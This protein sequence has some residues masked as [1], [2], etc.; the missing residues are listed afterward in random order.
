M[1]CLDTAHHLPARLL[2]LQLLVEPCPAARSSRGSPT[3][4]SRV[5]RSA[6]R[7]R[8]A[9]AATVP[10]SASRS[11]AAPLPCCRRSSSGAAASCSRRPAQR[12]VE[13]ELQDV[14][15][16]VARVRRVVGHVVLGA[17]V[18]E[19]LAARRRRRDA[20][21]LQPQVPPRLVVVR[22]RDLAGEHLPAPLVDQQAE[23][24]ER[25]LLERASQQQPDVARGI[26]APCRAGRSSR[27]IR[28]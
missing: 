3:R 12:A 26:R 22:R 18:E 19:L 7:A 16:E 11:A 14:G 27:G 24:Q 8:R 9:T 2:T 20:L 17:G 6:P 28:A 5:S 1:H 4:P 21:V 13:L 15:Q 25:D 23:G 10:S